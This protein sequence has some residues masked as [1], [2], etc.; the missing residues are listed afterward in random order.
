MAF[1][2]PDSPGYLAIILSKWFGVQ[3][4]LDRVPVARS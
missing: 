4:T 3:V 2:K 1:L